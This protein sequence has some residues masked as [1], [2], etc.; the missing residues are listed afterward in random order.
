MPKVQKWIGILEGL[1]H[2]CLCVMVG[3]NTR[4]SRAAIQTL[5]GMVGID[6]RHEELSARFCYA[7]S[8]RPSSFMTT[9]V[10]EKS[11]SF[12][13]RRSC[14]AQVDTHPILEEHVQLVERHRIET[15]EN[16]STEG[17]NPVTR[18]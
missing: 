5:T 6:R 9:I 18:M 13:K 15:I 14:F 12:P 2:R 8:T 10:R 17:V 3:V 1:Q 7:I 4:T 11:R 16:R